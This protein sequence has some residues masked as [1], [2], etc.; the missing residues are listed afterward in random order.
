MARL[1]RTVIP[2]VPHHITQRG[3][4]RQDV[5]FVDGDRRVYLSYLKESAARY[6][7]VVSAYCLMTNH[8]HLV[9]TPETETCLSITLGRPLGDDAFISNIETLLNRRV[10]AIPRGR[11]KGSKD[12]TKR[13]PRGEHRTTMQEVE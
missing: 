2:G 3:N 9:V 4:N 5:F 13:K 6:G 7:V 11:P 1:A 8:V 12:K 10:R